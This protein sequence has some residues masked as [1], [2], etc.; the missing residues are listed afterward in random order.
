MRNPKERNRAILEL[1]Q[2]YAAA[3]IADFF[4]YIIGESVMDLDSPIY[5]GA[6]FPVEARVDGRRFA[7]FHLDVAAGDVLIEPLESLTCRDWLGFAGI[8]SPTVQAISAEQQFAEKVHAYTLPRQHPN[9]RVRDLL[10]MLLLIESG[11]VSANS[12]WPTLVATFERRGTHPIPG[13]LP[14]PPENWKKPFALLA[15]DCNISDNI[16]H[17]FNKVIAFWNSL[18]K[19]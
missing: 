5:G 17:A 10:D 3:E 4:A 8:P 1:L 9:S 6:R 2:E 12:T 15:A 7:S 19:E 14:D 11:K 13:H 16:G 18:R